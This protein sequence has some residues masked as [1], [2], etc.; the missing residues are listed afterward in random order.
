MERKFKIVETWLFFLANLTGI[1]PAGTLSLGFSLK[2][3]GGSRMAFTLCLITY[4]LPTMS[5]TEVSFT[6]VNV[7]YLKT[8]SLSDQVKEV[9]KSP[10]LGS[11]SS[12]SRERT[13]RNVQSLL[14][15][16]KILQHSNSKSL[17]KNV[18]PELYC[19]LKP[20]GW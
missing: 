13:G 12:S 1:F 20:D 8:D 6:E 3:E 17:G 19:K 18:L 9:S 5:D 4:F 10:V 11:H 15:V 14:V 2:S 16:L 7:T